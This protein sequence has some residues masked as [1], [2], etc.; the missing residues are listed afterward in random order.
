MAAAE[1]RREGP[2]VSSLATISYWGVLEAKVPNPPKASAGMSA[3]SGASHHQPLESTRNEPRGEKRGS[4][5]PVSRAPDDG[6][7]SFSGLEQ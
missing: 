7:P 5:A 3:G 1:R 4:H 6:W 2:S